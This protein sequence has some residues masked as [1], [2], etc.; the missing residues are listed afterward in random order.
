MRSVSA[1]FEGVVASDV[2][3]IS[4]TDIAHLVHAPELGHGQ[5]GQDIRV[6]VGGE[7]STGSNVRAPRLDIRVLRGE[8]VT[9]LT[10]K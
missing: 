8:A 3:I 7:M 4:N 1:F 2:A 5:P 10:N 6:L 9:A